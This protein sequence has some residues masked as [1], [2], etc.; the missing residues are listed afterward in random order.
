MV[1]DAATRLWLL[2]EKLLDLSLLQAG[3]LEPGVGLVLARGRASRGRRA[4]RRSRRVDFALSIDRELP[5]LQADPAQLERAFVNVLENAARYSSGKPGVGARACRGER[6]CGCASSTAVRASRRP[7]SERVFLPFYRWRRPRDGPPRLG[8]RASRSPGASSRSTA[9]ASRSSR[10]PGQGTSFVIEFPLLEPPGEPVPSARAGR[11]PDGGRAHP[12]L[13]RRP[14]D[15]A[16][17]A[18]R[19]ARGGLRGDW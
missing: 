14:A 2:I 13:R 5:P 18:A 10:Q 7:S 11:R 9:G 17:A 16:G 1:L 6:A 3:R 8:A 15:P 12:R 4:D 19:A